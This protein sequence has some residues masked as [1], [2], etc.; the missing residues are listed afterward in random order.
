MTLVVSV[1]VHGATPDG[2]VMQ[3]TRDRVAAALDMYARGAH[4]EGLVRLRGKAPLRDTVRDFRGHVASWV[5]ND[6]VLLGQ[7]RAVAM[8]VTV[9]LAREAVAGTQAEYAA[10]RPLVE[11]MCAAIRKGPRTDAER[12]F[13]LATIGLMQGAG[14]EFGILGDRGG[15]VLNGHLSHAVERFPWEPRL[16]LALIMTRPEMLVVATR[17]LGRE[18]PLTGTARSSLPYADRDDVL[19]DTFGRLETLTQEPLLEHEVLL[20]RGVLRF[21][22]D[23]ADATVDLQAAAQ[24]PEPFVRYLAHLMLGI[25]YERSADTRSAIAAYS[26]AV[27]E[28]PATA[29][30][31]ALASLLF[32]EGQVDDAAQVAEAWARRPNNDDPWRQFVFG[33]YRLVPDFLAALRRSR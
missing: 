29:A 28:T 14:D 25:V 32:R 30:S 17:P 3:S 9:E 5:D 33:D 10:V 23:A 19:R 8:A 24:S 6:P 2:I 20:R 22:S 4:A 12:L 15:G 13:H 31:M 11:W 21:L 27:S 18:L 1:A 26:R 7:R 16:K